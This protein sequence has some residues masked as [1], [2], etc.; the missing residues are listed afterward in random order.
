MHSTL[1]SFAVAH[2][3][4]SLQHPAHPFSPHTAIQHPPSPPR[5]HFNHISLWLWL[6]RIAQR[7]VEISA[8]RLKCCLHFIDVCTCTRFST[9]TSMFSCFFL[10]HFRFICSA[11]ILLFVPF[12]CCAN[13]TKATRS[14]AQL[15]NFTT[16]VAFSRSQASLGFLSSW[17][18]YT[19]KKCSQD[20]ELSCKT[21]AYPVNRKW[22]WCLEVFHSTTI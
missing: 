19:Q 15:M 6:H 20:W 14:P 16:S 4:H 22:Y 17:Q 3:L 2:S 13:W 11:F 5:G 7:L 10:S 21:T 1:P 9:V 8:Q 12:P 18:P